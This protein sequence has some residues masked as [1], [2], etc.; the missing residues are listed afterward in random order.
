MQGLQ[1]SAPDGTV[2]TSVG[3]FVG[4]SVGFFV[5]D[6]VGFFVGDCRRDIGARQGVR[7]RGSGVHS[8]DVHKTCAKRLYSPPWG[9]SSANRSGSLLATRWDS[10]L[11]TAGRT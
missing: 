6:S 4:D 3:F 5:G 7:E 9:S 1:L 10:S 2:L 8:Q 11:E